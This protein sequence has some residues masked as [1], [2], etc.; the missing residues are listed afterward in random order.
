MAA[1]TV[2]V[3]SRTAKLIAVITTTIFRI[4]I[5]AF[6][7]LL[8]PTLPC[9]V[10]GFGQESDTAQETKLEVARASTDKGIIGSARCFF[11]NYRTC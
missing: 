11:Y 9:F 3:S 5:L 6:L 8:E 10:S 7:Y 1:I 2:L 4:F